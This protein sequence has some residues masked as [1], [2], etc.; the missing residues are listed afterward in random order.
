MTTADPIL[1]EIRD[2]TALIQFNQLATRNSLSSDT[3]TLLEEIIFKL[4]SQRDIA[5]LIFTGTANVFL[6]GANIGEIENL[7]QELASL[8]A[9]RGQKLFQSIADAQQ[10]TIAAINGHCMGGGLD[11]AL[12]CDIRVAAPDAEFAHPG[13]RLGIITGWG[14]TQRLPRLIGRIQALEFFTTA[15]RLTAVESLNLGLIHAVDPSPV[16]HSLRLAS[17]SQRSPAQN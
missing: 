7:D 13:A 2:S 14:G 1:L 9:E 10:T 15:R 3:L 4:T 17:S 5:T 12:A 6:S 8:F 16:T 11:F